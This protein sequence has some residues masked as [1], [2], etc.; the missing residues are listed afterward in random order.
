MQIEMWQIEDVKAYENNPRDNSGAVDAVAES[1]KQFGFKVP[2]I[3]DKDGVLIAGHTRILAARKLG[4]ESVPVIKAEDLTPDQVKAFRIADNKLHE[5]S[6]WDYELL[7]LELASLQEAN[8]DLEMLGFDSAELAKLLDPAVNE[9]LSDENET[10]DIPAEPVTKPGDVWVLGNHRLMCGDSTSEG[11]VAKLMD[12]KIPVLLVCDPPYGVAYNPQWRAEAGINKSKGRMGA[13]QNDDRIDW[14]PSYKLSGASIAYVWHAGKYA[15]QVKASLEIAE[16]EIIAQ[17]IW[18]KDRFA[19]S[20]GD[21]H[22]KHEPCWYAHKVGTS[23]NWQ[24]ARDQCT[25]WD[26]NRIDKGIEGEDQ[27]HGTQ[28]PVECMAR[29][30]LNNT[31]AGDLVYDAFVGSGTTIIAAEKYGRTCYAMEIDPRYCDAVISR[32]EKYTGKKANRVSFDDKTPA[33]AGADEERE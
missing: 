23:H 18:N 28:K 7:P 4:M 27:G 8:F 19:L 30:I 3:V 22:W 5:L 25:V 1:I 6:K 32:W 15:A 14:T 21:Y 9:G 29:P 2:V 12:G 33:E 24:G 13:V 16:Y 20:R 10:A 31:S 17:I 26:I 11:D